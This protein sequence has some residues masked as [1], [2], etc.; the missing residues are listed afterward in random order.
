MEPFYVDVVSY[1]QSENTLRFC[2]YKDFI[3]H[4]WGQEECWELPEGVP[5]FLIILHVLPLLSPGPGLVFT[6]RLFR[7]GLGLLLLKT[8][9]SQRSR[10][11]PKVV[12]R[13]AR[14]SYYLTLFTL[15]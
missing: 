11:V 3:H 9:C 13:S 10:A 1:T 7:P 4:Y 6:L 12:G 15:D 8:N 5:D 2:I 14:L